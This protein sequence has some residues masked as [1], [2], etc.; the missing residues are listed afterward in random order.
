MG[1]GM[2][3]RDGFIVMLSRTCDPAKILPNGKIQGDPDCWDTYF[4]T[5]ETDALWAEFKTNGAEVV[6][7]PVIRE[8]Y[9]MKEFAIR[10]LDRYVLVFGQDWPNKA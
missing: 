6:Y 4:W 7:E 8:L 1:G 9:E 3:R 10:H 5:G 2:P